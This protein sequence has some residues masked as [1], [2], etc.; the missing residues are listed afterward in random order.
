MIRF[1]CCFALASGDVP[2][3]EDGYELW[4]RYRPLD[5]SPG[6]L[7]EIVCPNAA[8]VACDE[9]HRGLAV[10]LKQPDIA[11]TTQPSKD[12]ALILSWNASESIGLNTDDSFSVQAANVKGFKAC[13]VIQ[14]ATARAAVYGAF[15]YGR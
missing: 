1:A 3:D 4:L 2:D 13:T 6:L 12:G 15:R 11:V 8:S 5:Q 14:G 10:M 9:L 7:S